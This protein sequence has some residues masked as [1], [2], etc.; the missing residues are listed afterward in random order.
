MEHGLFSLGV[1]SCVSVVRVFLLL[2][3]GWRERE[4]LCVE[5]GAPF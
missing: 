1:V 4:T 5:I 2:S 3:K